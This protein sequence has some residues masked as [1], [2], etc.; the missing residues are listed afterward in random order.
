LRNI[1]IGLIAVALAA[2]VWLYAARSFSVLADRWHTVVIESRSPYHFIYQ[3]GILQFGNIHLYTMTPEFQQGPVAAISANGR[4]SLIAGA[5]SFP[6]GPGRSVLQ[7]SGLPYF[8]FTADAGDVVRLSLERSLVSWPTPF[9]MNFMTGSAPSWKRHA[10]W[11]LTWTKPSRAKLEMLWRQEQG[12]YSRDGAWSPASVEVITSGLMRTNI[13][14]ASDLENAAVRH[15]SRTK[16]WDRSEYRLESRGP[17]GDGR[18]E[19]IFA[20]HRDD[21]QSPHPG[22]GRS[23]ELRVGYDSREVTREIGAQ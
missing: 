23:I 10:Y 2:V 15:L 13:V 22:A 11:R 17:S 6:L 14:E 18:E 5:T 4:V 21:E 3:S 8:E 7:P 16:H 9:E 20:I 12:Y 19:V 1:I